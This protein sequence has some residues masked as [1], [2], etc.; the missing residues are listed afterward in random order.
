[1]AFLSL[2]TASFRNLVDAQIDT[3]AKNIFLVGENGQGKTNFLEALYFCAYASSFRGVKDSDLV[4]SGGI[5]FSAAAVLGQLQSDAINTL[6]TGEVAVLLPNHVSVKV[7]KTRKTITLDGKKIMD[8]KD[9]L[10]TVPVVVFCHEDM[11]FVSGSQEKRRWFFDQT[12][13]LYDPVYL[14]DLR[15]YR[16]VLKTR[17]TVLKD[18][19]ADGDYHRTNELL[20]VLDP[21]LAEY[22]LRLMEKR[23]TA[24]ERFSAVF[25]PLYRE[26]SGIEG[27]TVCYVPSWKNINSGQQDNIEAIVKRLAER[28]TADL[29]QTV[30]LSG[31]HRDR[32]HYVQVQPEG[33]YVKNE[34]AA[35]F[36]G[37]ASTGQRRLLALLLRIAQSRCFSDFTGKTP[38]LLLDDV[39]LELDGE[40]RHRFL[41]VM[42]DYEQAFY[43]FLPEEPYKKYSN[44]GTLVYYVKS[45]GVGKTP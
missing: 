29:A 14:D 38:V 21:Q 45:G 43:T 24:A 35:E 23:S 37:N 36:A 40:K 7:E 34:S 3:S 22:G 20:D 31:P 12:Q 42:P 26:V 33:T 19:K 10:D 11:E 6:C 28:R 27:I 25:S 9:L 5:S 16:R 18:T 2:C 41:S 15:K 30:T 1:M 8:R 13:S 32:Y 44:S 17:N 4:R 39:L